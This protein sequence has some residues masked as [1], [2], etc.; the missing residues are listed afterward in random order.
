MKSPII[1]TIAILISF[2]PINTSV[3]QTPLDTFLTII[4]SIETTID[5]IEMN[6]DSIGTAVDSI[7]TAVDSLSSQ[8]TE[9][10]NTVLKEIKT[11]I[12]SDKDTSDQVGTITLMKEVNLYKVN[13]IPRNMK[14]VWKKNW[15]EK[16]RAKG[17]K[18]KE[19]INER[20]KEYLDSIGVV[21]INK[22]ELFIEDGSFKYLRAYTNQGKIFENQTYFSVTRFR[23]YRSNRIYNI[24]NKFKG[25][26]EVIILGDFLDYLT[27]VG[28]NYA[29]S[30]SDAPLQIDTLTK[31][32]NIEIKAG[33]NSYIGVKTYT[34]FLS[35]IEKEPNGLVQVEAS[36]R[37]VG[38]TKNSF[39]ET[40][41]YFVNYLDLAL[42]F[43]KFD[44]D[45]DFLDSN[46]IKIDTLVDGIFLDVGRT[47]LN[48]LSKFDIS[49]NPNI[50]KLYFKTI[51]Y[52]SLS[53]LIKYQY[54]D[55]KLQEEIH[56]SNL[57]NLG[58]TFEYRVHRF[59]NFGLDL[60]L[61]GL[62]QYITQKTG[63]NDKIFAEISNDGWEYFWVPEIELYY[64]P[65]SKKQNKIYLRFISVNRLDSD[66]RNYVQIQVG[67]SAR[68]KLN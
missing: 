45:F 4:D 51:N 35:L 57:V 19:Y 44:N 22:V 3:A 21:H 2:I 5:S 29:P 16:E 39:R 50:F 42:R 38:N 68:I 20:K 64:Y 49:I 37:I 46:S 31:S 17:I 7:E 12:N 23:N 54:S 61:S 15:R 34:D 48:Q 43:S 13:R 52:I 40:N 53:A 24:D 47:R 58:L 66:E 11:R 33:L 67:Y 63:F 14:T 27:V 25:I 59:K 10:E 28:N 1:L 8:L 9:F 41:F 32:K 62:G 55:I 60:Q 65:L 36:S 30:D 18:K 26:N 6:V 56:T